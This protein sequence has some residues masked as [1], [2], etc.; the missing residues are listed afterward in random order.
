MGESEEAHRRPGATG[1]AWGKQGRSPRRRAG[2]RPAS[3]AAEGSA[4]P[5]AKGDAGGAL[6]REDPIS[7]VAQQRT[8]SVDVRRAAGVECHVITSLSDQAVGLGE[9]SR[10]PVV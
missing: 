3:D 6:R 10:L 9:S 1:L 5:P 2:A 4:S 7:E 8:Q